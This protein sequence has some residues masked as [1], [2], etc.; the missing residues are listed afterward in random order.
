M[1]L[2]AIRAEQMKLKHSP[3]WLAF[4]ILPILPACMGTFN[5]L[6]NIGILK[7]Q[8]YSLWT[9]HTLFT[10]YFFLPALIGV[11]CSYL[12]RLEHTNHNWNTVM[13]MPIPASCIYLA[14]L[15]T[16]SIMLFFTQAWIGILFILS[17]KLIHLSSA[18][19]SGLIYWLLSGFIASTV[20]AAL[21]LIISFIIRSF[22]VPV[23]I[24]MIGGIAGLAV[25]AKG[26]GI[27]FP[28]SLLCLGMRANNPEGAL[29]YHPE[30]FI[31][32][33]IIYLILF[34]LFSVLWLKKCDVHA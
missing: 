17:G 30:Q 4:F 26:F 15:I 23:G 14:K 27:W 10:C 28:Y 32:N 12:C 6:Q 21:Q 29:P 5:Y 8:W 34:S 25:F 33:S 16:V 31:I 24:A 7:N 18:I 1:L 11:Y 19:P 22:A 2:K 20:I 13:T 9:Q 3:I